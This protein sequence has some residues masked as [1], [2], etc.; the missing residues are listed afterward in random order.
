MT[1]AATCA[2]GEVSPSPSYY[3]GEQ[4]DSDLGLY[5]L[6]A[7]YYNPATGRFLSR[8]PEGGKAKDPVSLH[9]YLYANGDP[10]NGWDP[11]GRQD[12]PEFALLEEE[13]LPALREALGKVGSL[14]A[15]CFED[16]ALSLLSTY[17]AVETGSHLGANLA[18]YAILKFSLCLMKVEPICEEGLECS[19]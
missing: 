2:F 13:T 12:A 10:V 1:T 17:D 3:R 11:T 18:G 7:R 8:D 5:Y 15:R 16:V 19:P 6:R 4:F 14:I 9:K